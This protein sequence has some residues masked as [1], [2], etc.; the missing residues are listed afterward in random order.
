MPGPPAYFSCWM[1]YLSLVVIV[2]LVTMRLERMGYAR[3]LGPRMRSGALHSIAGVALVQGRESGRR[4][5]TIGGVVRRAI[6][7]LIAEIE[8]R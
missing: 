5:A 7:N 4:P 2:A 3:R 1:L 8:R 6:P